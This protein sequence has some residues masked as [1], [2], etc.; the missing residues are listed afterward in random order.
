LRELTVGRGQVAA[1]LLQIG[2]V[3]AV[4]GMNKWLASVLLPSSVPSNIYLLALLVTVFAMLIHMCLGS[5][6]ACMGIVTPTITPVAPPTQRCADAGPNVIYMA[7]TSD[8]GPL[9]KQVTPLLMAGSP[10]YRAVFMPGTSCGGVKTIFDPTA[11]T[12]KDIAGTLT[13]AATYAYY[14][15]D[16][17]TQVSC[18]LDPEGKTVEF[19]FGALPYGHHGRPRTSESALTKIITAIVRPRKMSMETTR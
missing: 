16:A 3:G 17:G 9:L 1:T 18:T 8:F 10:A 5:A 12:I 11:A 14:F 15:D 6:L 4:T 7:G 13:K 19:E 2:Q